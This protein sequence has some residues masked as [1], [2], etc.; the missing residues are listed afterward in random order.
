VVCE[1]VRYT[2]N[3]VPHAGD[4]HRI[5][6]HPSTALRAGSAKLGSPVRRSWANW[7][8]GA[9]GTLFWLCWLPCVTLECRVC[10]QVRYTSNRVP[11][12]GRPQDS[13]APFDCAQGRLRETGVPASPLLGE[14]GRR[15]AGYALMALLASLRHAR[16]PG[17]R[18]SSIHSNRV[19]QKRDGDRIAQ[20]PSTALRAGSA[21]LG[22]PVRRSWANWGGG[23]LGRLYFEI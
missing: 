8:G 1:Q 4:G 15:S 13:P 3:Q 10:E 6:Q 23:V 16:M 18:A 5:A 14:L 9:L 7:G 21:K 22:V 20:H 19:P 12:A 2:S 11:H 17:L